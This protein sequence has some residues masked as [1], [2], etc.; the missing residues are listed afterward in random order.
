MI[1]KLKELISGSKSILITTHLGADPDAVCSSLLLY[2]TLKA[3]FPHKTVTVT[4]EEL[5]YGLD[6]LDDFSKIKHSPL[7]KSIDHFKPELLII[8]D[9]NNLSRCTRYPE[10]I[11]ET[12]K[13][14]KIAVIDHHEQ[15]DKG[16]CDVYVNQNSPAVTQDIYDIC[17]T[18]LGLIK[19]DNYATLTL[20][21]IYSD[22]G[23]FIHLTSGYEKTFDIVKKLV[24]DGA[25]VDKIHRQLNN[26][27]VESTQVLARLLENTDSY[28]GFTYSYVGDSDIEN[29]DYDD[30]KQ[31][32]DNY[33]NNYL[34]NI[35]NRGSGF[36]V[37]Q[38]LNNP[39]K[40]YKVSFRSLPDK[41]DVAEI[42]GRL[43]GGGHKP[44]AGASVEAQ[45]LDEAI[46]KVKQAI[47]EN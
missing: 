33:V 6:Y 14:T 40:A 36:V 29:F 18:Q 22:T 44:A 13:D 16:P 2:K 10:K 34:R 42:A 23:G 12:I 19:P 30:I 8:L 17:F 4:I 5:S 15:H 9:A 45:T 35:E 20:T 37:Y 11:G 41:H 28:A 3:N 24:A 1:D 26:Y 43:G 32:V 21:G 39:K 25:S 47:H 31:G 38:D 46:D 7:H 27:S